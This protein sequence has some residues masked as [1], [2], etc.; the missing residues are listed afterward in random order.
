MVRPEVP[1]GRDFY[2]PG[3]YPHQIKPIG[4]LKD[5]EINPDNLPLTDGKIH[6]I[7]QVNGE[8]RISVLNEAFKVG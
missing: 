3:R 5:V 7:R 2:R 6:F 4:I 8:G 1:K